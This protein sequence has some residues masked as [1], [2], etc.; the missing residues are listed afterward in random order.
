MAKPAQA[1]LPMDI[2]ALVA[3]LVQ[4]SAGPV[5]ETASAMLL[6]LSKNLTVILGHNGFKALFD[7][8]MHAA[9][10]K[11]PWLVNA[12]D[13]SDRFSGPQTLKATL[14]QQESD[15]AR[16]ATVLLFSTLLEL[17]VALIGQALTLK[18]L[19]ASWGHAFDH[20]VQELKK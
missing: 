17:L 3:Q 20:A 12:E 2:P 15:E 7:R 16:R 6:P 11:H 18:L 8:A 5:A 9:G 4:Q 10:R 1:P 19:S 14:G 13:A